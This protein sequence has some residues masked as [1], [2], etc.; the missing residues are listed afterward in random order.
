MESHSKTYVNLFYAQNQNDDELEG[1]INL[2]KSFPSN[3]FFS[4]FGTKLKKL[5]FHGYIERFALYGPYISHHFIFFFLDTFICLCSAAMCG[6][7]CFYKYEVN[8]QTR[9]I[10][11]CTWKLLKSNISF[12][13]STNI[14]SYK[15]WT[16]LF[17]NFL[18][19]CII[20]K[21][22]NSYFCECVCA[23]FE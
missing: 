9:A 23:L 11:F 13:L 7:V 17:W 22:R 4:L 20:F 1:T 15:K 6:F 16:H 8:V 2:L 5:R 3:L 12:I 14:A 21:Q 18:M 19:E 10:M